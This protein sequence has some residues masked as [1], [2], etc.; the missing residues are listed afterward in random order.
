V[1]DSNARPAVILFSRT[2]ITMID[3][4]SASYYMTARSITI[5]QAENHTKFSARNVN[6]HV[7]LVCPL[8]SHTH[9]FPPTFNLFGAWGTKSFAALDAAVIRI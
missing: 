7:R 2:D 6:N 1:T 9:F 8:P 4:T 3:H 5:K